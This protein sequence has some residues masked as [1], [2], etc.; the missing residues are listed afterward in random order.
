M[1]PKFNCYLPYNDD[2]YV[3][4]VLMILIC[5]WEEFLT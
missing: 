4:E 2:K 1:D 3:P 5:L